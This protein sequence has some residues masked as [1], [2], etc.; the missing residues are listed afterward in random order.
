MQYLIS[1][2]LHSQEKSYISLTLLPIT[3]YMK[4]F[5]N[6]LTFTSSYEHLSLRIFSILINAIVIRF[7]K[8]KAL[9]LK[10][11]LHCLSIYTLPERPWNGVYIT[12]GYWWHDSYCKLL[13]VATDISKILLDNIHSNINL[14]TFYLT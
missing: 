12:W 6:F 11:S 9:L 7:Q 10:Q 5:N 14:L 3:A 4:N 8:Q 1:G 13:L 2:L